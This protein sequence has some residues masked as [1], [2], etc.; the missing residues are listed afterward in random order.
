MIRLSKLYA[1]YTL[2]GNEERFLG[3]AYLTAKDLEAIEESFTGTP[4]SE[5][6][7]ALT[8]GDQVNVNAIDSIEEITDD[9]E[10]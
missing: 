5:H 1:I 8:D 9:G 2:T 10:E 6:Y 7:I 4:E 3:Q